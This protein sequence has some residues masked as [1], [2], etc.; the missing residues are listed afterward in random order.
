M[1]SGLSLHIGLNRVDPA[2]YDGWDGALNACEFDALDMQAIAESCGFTTNL[3][4]TQ[5]ATADAVKAAISRA[6][7]ELAPGDLFFL[8]Y[9]GHG[10]QVPDRNGDDEVDHLDE[11]WVAFDRQLV[12]DELYALWGAFA[13]RARIVVLSDSCH[14]GTANRRIG[15]EAEVPNVVKTR[16]QADAAS[17]RY[18][19]MPQDVL[20]ATYRAHAALYDDIQK[21]VPSAGQAQPEATVLLISGCRDDQLSRDGLANGLFTEN[22]KA[23]WNDGAWD[24]GYPAFRETIRARMPQDQQPHYNPVGAGNPEF[25]QQ[26]PFSIG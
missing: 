23:V 4:L 10:G 22:L 8:S 1:A 25:E 11:T 20:A 21:Q 7:A 13:P 12:D 5:D 19:A 26:K 9:S 2:H 6:A 17:P 14:S 15:D 16:Q 24:G 18:R 3:L